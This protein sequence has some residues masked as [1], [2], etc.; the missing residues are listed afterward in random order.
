M[1]NKRFD[2]PFLSHAMRCAAASS[3]VLS[4]VIGVGYFFAMY[5][6]FNAEIGHFDPTPWFWIFSVGIA[7]AAL[8]AAVCAFLCRGHGVS[9][10]K[11]AA[12]SDRIIMIPCAAVARGIFVQF[13]IG[14][15]TH[16]EAY[17]LL[18]K[19]AGLFVLYLDRVYLLGFSR[20]R[21]KRPDS[22]SV[23]IRGSGNQP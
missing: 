4:L 22:D 8:I 10:S 5:S 2:I 1:K 17:S 15:F 20:R 7:L 16:R 19:G 23:Y 13:L 12:A 14:V 3:L 21:L 6:G 11:K 18:Q 9:Q